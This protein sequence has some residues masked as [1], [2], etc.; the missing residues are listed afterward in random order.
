MMRIGGFL[1]RAEDFRGKMLGMAILGSRIIPSARYK[2]AYAAIEWLCAV[3]GFEKRAV[4]GDGT[5]VHHAELTLGQGMFMLGSAGTHGGEFEMR[6]TTLAETGGR[7]TL[8]LCVLV[9]DCQAVYAR[10]MDAGAEIVEE[11]NQPE[12]GGE[13]FACKDLEGHIWWVGSYNPWAQ[14][15][16][17]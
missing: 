5:V 1:R 12:Y 13:A 17:S 7:E 9:E 3:F 14:P 2:D 10:A 4:H 11:L 16:Q 8:G 6:M 15:V